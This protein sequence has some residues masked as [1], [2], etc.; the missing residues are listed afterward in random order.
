[1]AK[2]VQRVIDERT[3]R[4]VLTTVRQAAGAWGSFRGLML[5]KG[6]PEGHGLLFRAAR[7]IHTQFM[8]FAIDLVFLDASDAVIKVR[9]AMPPWRFDLTNAAGVIEINPGAARANDIRPGDRLRFE[10]VV[11]GS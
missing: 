3:G 4:V 2:P 8:G 6:L 10:P 9:E 5:A 1:M 7:G 11:D